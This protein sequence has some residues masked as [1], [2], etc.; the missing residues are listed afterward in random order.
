MILIEN[1]AGWNGVAHEL[2]EPPAEL[3]G[4]VDE[5]MQPDGGGERERRASDGRWMPF[6]GMAIVGV[7]V[8]VA[9]AIG[10]AGYNIGKIGNSTL[11][12]HLVRTKPGRS[13]GVGIW[14]CKME[15][16][17]GCSSFR[18]RCYTSC[19]YKQLDVPRTIAAMAVAARVSKLQLETGNLHLKLAEKEN[20]IHVLQQRSGDPES[21]LHET[22]ETLRKPEETFGL[23]DKDLHI[24]F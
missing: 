3:N 12:Q 22:C 20:S 23:D 2:R 13:S 11:T 16:K 8:A 10:Y 6:I 5:T 14:R 4:V 18:K 9:V 19:R 24:A 15:E 7:G 21:T 1:P 17:P